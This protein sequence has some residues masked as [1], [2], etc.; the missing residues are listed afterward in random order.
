LKDVK[1]LVHLRVP[2]DVELGVVPSLVR[3]ALQGDI[4]GGIY[5]P[6]A[7]V[8]TKAPWEFFGKPP[9]DYQETE[10]ETVQTEIVSVT[11]FW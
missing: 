3:D 7:E 11:R 10:T 2:D 1:L 9:E 6:E 8:E 5:L 4:D